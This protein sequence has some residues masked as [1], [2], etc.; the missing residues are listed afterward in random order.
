MRLFRLK[1][2]TAVSSTVNEI[3][4]DQR[5]KEKKI[6]VNFFVGGRKGH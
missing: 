6:P 5:V 3:S 1:K 2:Q 4:E